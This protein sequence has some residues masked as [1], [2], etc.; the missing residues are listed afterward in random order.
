MFKITYKQGCNGEL[1]TNLELRQGDTGLL[2]VN[3][4]TKSTG[5]PIDFNLIDKIVFKFSGDNYKEVYSKILEQYED[6]FLLRVESHESVS[7]DADSFIYEIECTFMDGSV[8]TPKIGGLVI[9]EQI[10]KQEG[11]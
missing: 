4:K 9:T 1:V 3:P 8:D 7:F 6:Y 2:R 11:T 5:E 10:R